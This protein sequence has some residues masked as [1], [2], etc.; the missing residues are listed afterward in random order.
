M[1]RFFCHNYF[2]LFSGN[3]CLLFG[4]IPSLL[5]LLIPLFPTG[6]EDAHAVSLNLDES[7]GDAN[8]NTFFAVYDGHGG[9]VM[10][11][12]LSFPSSELS[13]PS[14]GSS[15][16][17]FAGQNVHRRLVQED[18]YQKQKY[19]EAMRRA[20]LGMDEEMLTSA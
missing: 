15:V 17:R 8:P 9:T 14:T 2:F 16:A 1:P 3:S 20:F 19:E 13:E 12:Y 10:T 6:M 5:D 18:S 11:L 4:S 7:Q